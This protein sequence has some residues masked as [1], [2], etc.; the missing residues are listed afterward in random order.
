MKA[1]A[2]EYRFRVAIQAVIYVLG[3]AAPWLYVSAA[4]AG[5]GIDEPAWLRAFDAAVSA[6]VADLQCGGDGAAG[7]WRWCSRG[8][9]RG[10][11]RGAE[12]MTGRASMHRGGWP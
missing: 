7:D 12:R 10:C 3:F 8:W 9:A 5:Q 11:G 1:S 6:R 4:P 2:F